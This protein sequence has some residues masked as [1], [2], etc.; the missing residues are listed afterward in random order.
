MWVALLI[1]IKL[2]GQWVPVV[3][4]SNE[5]WNLSVLRSALFRNSSIRRN[6][7]LN[8]AF[9]SCFHFKCL[10][11]CRI[12]GLLLWSFQMQWRP[13]P[14]I[15][16]GWKTPVLISVPMAPWF[17]TII[18]TIVFTLTRRLALGPTIFYLPGSSTAST[19]CPFCWRQRYCW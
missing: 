7:S 6:S 15:R 13:C 18:L 16:A 3:S 17:Q 4:M 5:P 10:Y 1:I 9:E 8:V 11:Y 12:S 2:L 19:R 14:R